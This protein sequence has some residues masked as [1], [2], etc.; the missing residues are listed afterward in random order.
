MKQMDAVYWRAV[1]SQ[2][3]KKTKEDDLFRFEHVLYTIYFYP[4]LSQPPFFC[5]ARV[6]AQNTLDDRSR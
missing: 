5:F 1:N 2:D 6:R 3:M 4:L